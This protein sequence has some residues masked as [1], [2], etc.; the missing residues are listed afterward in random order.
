MDREYTMSVLLL[1]LSVVLEST[2]IW[3][4][5]GGGFERFNF[6]LHNRKSVVY[7]FSCYLRSLS[8]QY[9]RL[10]GLLLRTTA[11]TFFIQYPCFIL[12]TDYIQ[13]EEGT[14]IYLFSPL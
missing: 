10:Y 14:T 4:Q 13:G 11:H 8:Y 9:S 1:R 2:F 12:S 6:H 7:H 5:R 3:I